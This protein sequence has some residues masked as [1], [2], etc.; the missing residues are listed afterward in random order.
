[1]KHYQYLVKVALDVPLFKV[2]DYCYEN[3]DGK[4]VPQRGQIVEIEFRKKITTA[5]ILQIDPLIKPASDQDRKLNT[6]ISLAP[7]APLPE[8]SLRLAEFTARYYLKPIGEVLMSS[9][10]NEWKK[11]SNWERLQ[12]QY[13]KN[14]NNS[15]DSTITDKHSWTL[16]KEQAIALERLE[17]STFKGGFETVLLKGVTGSGKT[18]VYLEWLKGTY[19]KQGGQYL[20]LVPE[21]NLTPQLEKVVKDVFSKELVTVLHSNLTPAQR[22]ISWMKIQDQTA[23][24]I[25]G[26]RLSILTP[27]PNLRGIV[28][29]E[30]HDQSYKQQDGIRYSARDL[31]I[32]R[33]SDEAFTVLLT[34]ATPS[35]ETWNKVI[36]KKITLLELKERAKLGAT[37][38]ELKLI[39]IKDARTQK[40]IDNA[41]ITTLVK[42]EILKTANEKKQTLVFI[43]RRGYSPVLHCNSCAWKSECVQCSAYMVV[44]KTGNGQQHEVKLHC[45]HCGL[46]RNP[47]KNCP[48]CGNSDL[49]PIGIGTQKIEEQLELDFP[50]L[51]ILRIDSDTTRKK[52]EMVR[53][54][55][56]IHDSKVDVI[57]GT[58]MLSKGHDFNQVKTVI[59]LDSDKSLYSQDFRAEEKLFAQL[60]QVAGRAGRDESAGVSQV[61]IQTEFPE[62][63]L[64]KALKTNS[65]ESYLATLLESRKKA[66][67]PP[68]VYQA[69]LIAESKSNKA[70]YQILLA[71]KNKVYLGSNWVEVIT[72]NDIVPKILQRLAGTERSQILIESSDRNQLQRFL[73]SLQLEIEII[74]H[75]SRTIKIIL[76]RDP[77]TY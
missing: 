16:N 2:F 8:S 7:L 63:E 34:S 66:N 14:T 73:E 11:P 42:G 37:T 75:K 45:H 76:E 22:N 59:V 46:V 29:D 36:N 15:K 10:P 6:I 55:D 49:M 54:I 1:M 70:N 3:L 23:K 33:G 58:Q 69:L 62:H 18:A 17:K 77:I 30:E 60:V 40:Q 25:V 35:L 28:V 71:L 39:S 13:L 32:W 19:G 67:L 68:Y 21:I 9:I 43:N 72:M 74:K 48:V 57:V 61:I 47:P 24:I 31:A 26:T 38:P 56:S 5:I 51:K 50:A 20:I 27:I 52:G 64:F 4:Q 53:L 41:G 44:H 12:K 65:N